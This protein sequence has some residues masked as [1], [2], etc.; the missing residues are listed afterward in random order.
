MEHP[1]ERLE[2]GKGEL[3]GCSHDEPDHG[4]DDGIEAALQVAAP[5]WSEDPR[6]DDEARKRPDRDGPGHNGQHSPE[7]LPL[8]HRSIEVFVGLGHDEDSLAAA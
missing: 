7:P 3:Q 6:K 1:P 8:L 4:P 5:A 2:Q